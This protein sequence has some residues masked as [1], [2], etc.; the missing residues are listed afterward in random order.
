[1]G[2]HSGWGNRWPR[3][4]GDRNCAGLGGAR[5]SRVEHPLRRIES[6]DRTPD[7]SFGRLRTGGIARS[8]H[9]A[10]AYPGQ[11]QSCSRPAWGVPA[12]RPN[13]AQATPVSSR[14][15]R[16]VCKCPRGSGWHTFGCAG[17]RSGAECGARTGESSFGSVRCC[18][19]CLVSRNPDAACGDHREPGPFGDRRGGHV[20]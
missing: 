11:H 15:G 5:T 10:T 16:G 20:G 6:R 7:G 12:R 17:S 19:C 8:R 3:S 13:P 9:S 1:M 4:S 14:G 2:G 18:V